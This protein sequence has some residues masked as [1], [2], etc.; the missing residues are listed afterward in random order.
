MSDI[1]TKTIK[2]CWKS[3]E[4]DWAQSASIGNSGGL[5]SIWNKAK[6]TINTSTIRQHWIAISGVFSHLQFEGTL[7]NIYNPCDTS[8]RAAVWREIVDFHQDNPLPCL[9]IR[10]F[11]EVLCPSERGSLIFSQTG[12]NDFK[13]F[14]Q[15]LHLLEIPSTSRCFTW[16]RGNSKSILDSLLVNPEWIAAFPSL[17]VTLL[18]R[19]LLDHCPLLVHSN[20]HNWGPEIVSVS[21][22]W[23]T[24][25]NCLKIVKQA[26]LESENLPTINK[27]REVKGKL[28]EWNHNEFGNIDTNI[29]LLEDEIQNLDNMNNIRPLTTLELE[30]RKNAQSNLWMWIKRKELYWAQNS[31]LTW[32]K[33][34][35]RNTKFFHAIA[36][37]KRRKNS[38]NSIE[39][40]GQVIDDPS[41]IK[42]E[43]AAFFKEIFTE[44]S[45]NRPTFEGLNFSHLSKD[46]AANLILPFSH[47]EID[48]V[49]ASCSSDKAPGPDGFNFKFIKNAWDIIKPDIYEVV[50]SFW[51][52]S[53]L[54]RGSNTTYIALIP[55][56]PNPSS[57]K[58]YRSI[59]MIGCI[60]K[61]IAKLMARRLQKV[62]NSLIG[63]LQS[64]YIEGRQILDG[65]LIAS[66]VIETCKRKGVD[67]T[68]L[69]LDFHKAYDS[70]SWSFLMWILEQMKFPPQWCDWVLSCISS[71]SASILI[72]GS[73][74]VPFKLQRGLRQ[75]D[76]ISPFLFVFIVEA[77]NQ[78][79]SKAT[80]KGLWRGVKIGKNE[81]MITHLQYA[82]D[83]LIFSDA[84]IE[85][86]LNIKCVLILFQLASGL[87]VNFHKSSLMGLNISK[88]WLK[89]AASSLLCKEGCIPFTYLGLPIGGNS[90]RINAWSPIIE[91]MSKR[92]ATWKGRL[93]SIGGRITL[94]KSSLTSLPLYY[95]SLF[96]MPK[97]VVNE[98]N[99]IIRAF[100]WCGSPEKKPCLLWRGI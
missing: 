41:S 71:T 59:S 65:A 86:L 83:T 74:S 33:D 37:N 96:H 42:K 61:I 77:L 23:L 93:L 36:S 9:L 3:D 34:G 79:I 72:N 94:I 4:I 5:L 30:E 12:A 25:P 48:E 85:S 44:N 1:N 18:P 53:Q 50:Q 22:C 92:L 90:S 13:N 2:T 66:E 46:Q 73:P 57:F 54:P 95:M 99:K 47:E 10:D 89:E 38:I 7:I 70:V 15:E 88:T 52:S 45:H 51:K 6:F 24:D 75:G 21:Y 27:L 64:S 56:I 58:D 32:L 97:G 11:N 20:S 100:L 39:I 82:D 63:P 91:K 87:Q 26:W 76:P 60:Y 69:K 49:V 31:R 78:L 98:I 17:K 28:K 35:D 8:Q 29:K 62:M 43:A 68:L 67:A 40:D 14:M 80:N 16:F 84:N 81:L 19:G 55:K